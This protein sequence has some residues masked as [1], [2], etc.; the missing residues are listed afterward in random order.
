MPTLDHKESTVPLKKR[1]NSANADWPSILYVDDDPNIISSMERFF[2]RYRVR[3]ECA[4][5]GM[6]G[7]WLAATHPPDLIITDLT[8]PLASGEELIDCLAAHPATRETPIVVL[9][10][11]NNVRLNAKLKTSGVIEVLQKPVAFETLFNLVS[12][13]VPLQERAAAG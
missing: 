7:I 10:G 11:R 3:L 8:M 13:I 2:H 4:Y 6:Q 12:R 9:S 1:R 5:H